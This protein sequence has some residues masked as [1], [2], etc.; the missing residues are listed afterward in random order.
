MA[1]EREI[2]VILK[3][4][5][6]EFIQR[7]REKGYK[8]KRSFKQKDTYFDTKD[9]YLYKNIAALRLRQIENKDHSFS[10]KKIFYF[11]KKHGGYYVEELIT[12]APFTKKNELF[13]IFDR[14]KIPHHSNSIKSFAELKKHLE[15]NKFLGEQVINKKRTIYMKD[16]NEFVIDDIDKVGI[17]VELE[18]AEYEPLEVIKN[19]LS[20]S[21]WERS[22]EGTS[23]RWLR[24]VRGFTS[25]LNNLKRF[26]S[27]PN[28]NV[29]KNEKDWYKKQNKL[30]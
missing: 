22:V 12:N 23:F 15:N 14:L 11:P 28:W 24:N 2:K 8:Q 21:E 26:E 18:C 25:H 27:E 16:R 17:T 7:I 20:K 9:W 10:F 3:I 4:P 5:L 30:P 6:K 13:E 29:W 1:R 19:V